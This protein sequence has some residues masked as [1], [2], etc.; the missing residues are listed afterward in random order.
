[1]DSFVLTFVILLLLFFLFSDQVFFD[2]LYNSILGRL[3]IIILLI[4]M[5]IINIWLSFL[6]LMIVIY[7]SQIN[8]PPSITPENFD[9]M[10]RVN[11]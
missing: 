4:T 11:V 1:M 6:F 9:N 8:A 10:D 3:V 5:S 7:Y 2:T